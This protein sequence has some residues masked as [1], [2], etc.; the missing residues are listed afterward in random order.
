MISGS[1]GTTPFGHTGDLDPSLG[2][3]KANQAGIFPAV[4][5]VFVISR[6]LCV[7]MIVICTGI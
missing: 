2:N 7:Q 1:S 4:L 5:G 3:D 6:R